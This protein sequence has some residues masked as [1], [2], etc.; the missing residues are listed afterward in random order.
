MQRDRGAVLN[1][2][3]V[4]PSS[5]HATATMRANRGRD[6]RPELQI[7]SRLHRMGLRFRVDHRLLAAGVSC[8]PDLVFAGARVVVFVDGCF[9]H[10]CPRH[11]ELPRSNRSFWEE[12]LRRNSE[13]DRRQDA[14]LEADG[15][16]VIRVWEH[17][18]P[19]RAAH[20]IAEAVRAGKA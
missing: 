18:E 4:A 14:A 15:W 10:S 2:S 9:W 8:R 11:G 7:R 3:E 5:A 19:E 17:D 1:G 16:Q 13:R 12:K 6:S 20:W